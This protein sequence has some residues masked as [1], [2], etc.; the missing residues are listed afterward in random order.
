M[1]SWTKRFQ[2]VHG[3]VERQHDARGAVDLTDL[4][5]LLGDG[6]R[7]ARDEV[8]PKKT[9]S[10]IM[11]MCWAVVPGGVGQRVT[12]RVLER[13]HVGAVLVVLDLRLRLFVGVGEDDH[14][15]DVGPDV[16]AVLWPP[17][18]GRRW[19]CARLR[20]R[21]P[22]SGSCSRRI[23]AVKSRP[24]PEAPARTISISFAGSGPSLQSVHLQVLALEVALPGRPRAPCRILH[25]LGRVV[26]A[27]LRRA[28]HPATAHLVVLLLVVARD[29][30][31]PEAPVG[32]VVDGHGHA[33]DDAAAGS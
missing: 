26:V 4:L 31:D 24:R 22:A 25:V 23:A 14:L 28:R 11:P 29:D 13:L 10:R 18:A 3:L 19:P 16:T 21:R 9:D 12:E 32:D 17:R 6:L 8:E 1:T 30:V 15:Q 7:R 2:A 33:G 5:E 20:R 27:G